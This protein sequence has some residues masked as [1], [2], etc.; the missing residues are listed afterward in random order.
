MTRHKRDRGSQ[1]SMGHRNARI[2][3]N[4]DR[5]RHARHNLEVDPCSS[6]RFCLFSTTSENKWV[7]PFEPNHHVPLLGAFNEQSIDIGLVLILPTSP[8]TDIDALCVCRSI[9]QEDGFG[10]IIVEDDIGRLKA[11]LP[12]QRQK[13]RITWSRSDQIDL[14]RSSRFRHAVPYIARSILS[15]PRASSR[16][17]SWIPIDSG[18]SM[19]PSTI[20]RMSSLPSTLDT[21]P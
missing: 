21:N 1:R 12:F 16:S 17:A 14:P 7:A 6:H 13:S 20:S 8:P 3:R 18:S 2:G 15:P 9:L 19:V 11:F 4:R 10:E 5:R